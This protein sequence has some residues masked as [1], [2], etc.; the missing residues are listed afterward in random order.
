MPIRSAAAQA[1]LKYERAP[2]T[3]KRVSRPVDLPK[4][5]TVEQAHRNHE[6]LKQRIYRGELGLEEGETLCRLELRSVGALEATTNEKDLRFVES[7]IIPESVPVHTVVNSPVPALPGT[8]IAVPDVSEPP[9]NGPWSPNSS[10][11]PEPKDE[12]K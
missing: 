6:E 2:C 1:I 9:K 11:P 3:D 12:P 5:M 8:N 7:V 10:K 4:A